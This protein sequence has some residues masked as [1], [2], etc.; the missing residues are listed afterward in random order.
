MKMSK[1][2]GLLILALLTGCATTS[3][4]EAIR[5]S[6][7]SPNS[8]L[9]T[10][11]QLPGGSK[12]NI[13]QSMIMGSGSNWFGR[14]VLELPSSNDAY[15]FFLEQYPQQGWT[16]ISAVRGKTS[17]L[18]FSRP[19]RS[20]TIEM[21]DG[22]GLNSSN[23]VL[24]ISPKSTLPAQ[25]APTP[26]AARPMAPVQAQPSASSP[27][28]PAQPQSQGAPRP[29]AQPATSSPVGNRP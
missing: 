5:G 9:I 4:D 3:S 25:P 1:L 22:T 21:T 20:A 6:G 17:L 19:D 29:A 26:A 2:L 14:M 11:N 18:V 24:T 10:S 7:A 27:A 28:A 12:I 16:L 23:A 8:E 15:G 13:T